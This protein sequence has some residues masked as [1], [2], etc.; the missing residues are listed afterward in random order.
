MTAKRIAAAIIT[1]L[2][3]FG[4][5]AGTATAA[6]ARVSAT[7]FYGAQPDTHFYG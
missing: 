3:I 1:A 4:A 5:A 7:H 6:S 2:A